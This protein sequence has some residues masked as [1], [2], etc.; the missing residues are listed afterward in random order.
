MLKCQYIIYIN[1]G[2]LIP[3]PGF[4][5]VLNNLNADQVFYLDEVNIKIRNNTDNTD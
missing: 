4:F 1:I 5:D 2:Q 3:A